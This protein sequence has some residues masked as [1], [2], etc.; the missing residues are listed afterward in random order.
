MYMAMK[1][2]CINCHIWQFPKVV[3]ALWMESGFGAG[4]AVVADAPSTSQSG[5]VASRR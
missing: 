3:A 2:S 4:G 5:F 1:R